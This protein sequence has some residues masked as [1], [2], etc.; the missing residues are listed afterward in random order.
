MSAAV[1]LDDVFSSLGAFED[2]ASLVGLLRANEHQVLDPLELLIHGLIDIQ[3][4]QT[5][6][7]IDLPARSGSV[8]LISL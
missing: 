2:L 5:V 6:I 8:R 7:D 3:V 4:T 1:V